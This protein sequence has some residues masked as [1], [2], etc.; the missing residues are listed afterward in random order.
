MRVVYV[1]GKFSAPDQW[2]RSRNVRA[3][4]TVAFAVAEVGAMPLN[5]L[6]NTANFFGTLRDEF[7]Y[8][9]TLELLRRCD[10]VILVPGWE[11]SK[12]VA[13]EVKEAE[14]LGMK[15]FTR[16]EELKEWML[17]LDHAATHLAAQ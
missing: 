8:D 15:V 13:A 14:R 11:G 1:A 2:Q 16:V 17:A 7:W 6:A 5:P 9:G 4:E 12:G 10:A 3:A